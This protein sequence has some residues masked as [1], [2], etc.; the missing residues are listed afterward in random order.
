MAIGRTV[1]AIG[2]AL[3]GCDASRPEQGSS[4][5]AAAGGKA[6]DYEPWGSSGGWGGTSDTGDGDSGTETGES[7][8]DAGGDVPLVYATT[9][10]SLY[11]FDP[12]TFD[13][14]AVGEFRRCRGPVTEVAV[15]GAGRVYGLVELPASS[16]AKHE[17]VEIEIDFSRVEC[18]VMGEG[19]FGDNLAFVSG[20]TE[21]EGDSLVYF[22]TARTYNFVDIVSSYGMQY[23]LGTQLPEDLSATGDLVSSKDGGTYLTVSGRGCAEQTCTEPLPAEA[24]PRCEAT[25][26]IVEVDSRT[27]RFVRYFGS[28]QY[29]DVVGLGYWAGTLIGFTS[30]GV[31][32]E[33]D[34]S[35]LQ[36]G[37]LTTYRLDLET[38][39]LRFLGAGSSVAAPA[40]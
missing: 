38:D 13:F 24:E 35:D 26:C 12:A 37:R 1:V 7:D 27:G 22:D 40:R 21:S 23:N 2:L 29:D 33:L 28:L 17:L 34:E 20:T 11:R 16:V 39:G 25:D 19:T 5:D 8:P 15:N 14:K 9:G 10:D 36:E 6:D 31:A 3:A 18:V 32:F 4:P 30:A